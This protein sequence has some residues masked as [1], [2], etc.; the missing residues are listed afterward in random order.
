MCPTEYIIVSIQTSSGFAAGCSFYG[1]D[2][3]W[4]GWRTLGR[5]STV[6]VRTE[7]NFMDIY[8]YYYMVYVIHSFSSASLS[9]KETL[10]SSRTL[11]MLMRIICA[12]VICSCRCLRLFPV[13]AVSVLFPLLC[14][15]VHVR[16]AVKKIY[17]KRNKKSKIPYKTS[18]Y[19]WSPRQSCQSII[20]T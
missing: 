12:P 14:C 8:Y 13:C 6:Y 3:P 17:E 1:P 10:K 16:V 7:M 20:K 9:W 5:R 19:K 18:N 4:I 2:P 11:P 15:S